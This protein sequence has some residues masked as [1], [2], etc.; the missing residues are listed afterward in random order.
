MDKRGR[1]ESK[2]T[3]AQKIKRWSPWRGRKK[4]KGKQG[5]SCFV[6][7]AI[8]LRGRESTKKGEWIEMK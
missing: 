1:K 3:D 4:S 5:F 8:N 7:L 6:V 2:N